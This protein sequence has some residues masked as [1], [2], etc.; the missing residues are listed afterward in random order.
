MDDGAFPAVFGSGDLCRRGVPILNR[1]L[2]IST[3]RLTVCIQTV[4]I[5]RFHDVD[6]HRVIM[7]YS[8][9]S[10]KVFVVY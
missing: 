1:S 2:S 4:P 10:V 9:E 5:Y 6:V 8:K 7:P 3:L